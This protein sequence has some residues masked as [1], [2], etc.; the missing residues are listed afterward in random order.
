[1][2]CGSPLKA[3]TPNVK[4]TSGHAVTVVEAAE[5]PR[6]ESLIPSPG[7]PLVGDAPP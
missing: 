5:L 2:L 1:M 3:R 4:H 7:S 6:T